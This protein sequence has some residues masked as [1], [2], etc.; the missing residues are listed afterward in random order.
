V[1]YGKIIIKTRYEGSFRNN[2]FHGHGM[3]NNEPNGVFEGEF[4]DGVMNGTGKYSKGSERYAGE[5]KN[6][7]FHGHGMYCYSNGD[8]Y[9]GG[10]TNGKKDGKGVFYKSNNEIIEEE[11]DNGFKKKKEEVENEEEKE[12]I[13]DPSI[14][15]EK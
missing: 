11:W 3:F 5:F 10:F 8:R 4:I 6:G 9:E 14:I 7:L 15:I 12:K 2:K 1:D 13:V